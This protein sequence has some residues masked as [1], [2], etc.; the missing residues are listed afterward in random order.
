MIG[1]IWTVSQLYGA[2]DVAFARIFS[3]N[4]ERDIVRRTTRGFAVVGILVV[5]IV[6]FVVVAALASTLDAIAARDFPVASSL[7]SLASSL[8]FVILISVA[9]V[10]VV[11]RTLPP[12]AP[13]WRAALIPAAWSGSRSWS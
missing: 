5:A 4:P 6:G 11:Y 2:L 7:A 12:K 10:L 13:S 9:A 8:P 1:L 3:D